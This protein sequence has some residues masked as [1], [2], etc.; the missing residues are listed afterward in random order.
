MSFI[1]PGESSAF[2]SLFVFTFITD[3]NEE[4]GCWYLALWVLHEDSCWWCLDLQVRPWSSYQCLSA[5]FPKLGINSNSCKCRN[6]YLFLSSLSCASVLVA[7][8][9][10][11]ANCS[12]P[13][14][15]WFFG[16]VGRKGAEMMA[17]PS[18]HCQSWINCVVDIACNKWCLWPGE[19]F[20]FLDS[21]DCR[22][23]L[24]VERHSDIGTMRF[25]QH[26][27]WQLQLPF[28]LRETDV[29]VK[30]RFA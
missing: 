23:I 30:N 14:Q 8:L 20:F 1:A 6:K 15:G 16:S 17:G 3:Q 10:G 5:S 21:I 26:L 28:P 29:I 13:T 2:L 22:K 24:V 7:F 12:S 27:L 25:K 9:T 4:E 19:Y 18:S 11:D